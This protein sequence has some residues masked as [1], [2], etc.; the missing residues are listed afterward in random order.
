VYTSANRFA[1]L[2]RD[3]RVRIV[4]VTDGTSTTIALVEAAGRP[5]VFW[6]RAVQP[7]QSND[8]GICWADSEG[9]FSLD[10]ASADGSQE[11]CNLAGGCTFALNR[12]NN[13]EPFSFHSGGAH[14]VFT[15]GHVQFVRDSVSL[16]TLA[17]L[18]TRNAGE[19]IGS[20]L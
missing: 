10:G 7:T 20:D 1:V 13:N 4:D 2:H 6:N 3:S 17:A 12:R 9:P 19:V 16:V 11:G 5:Q 18:S 15:D 8:Q 14:V